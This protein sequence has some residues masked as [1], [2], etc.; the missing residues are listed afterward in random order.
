MCDGQRTDFTLVCFGDS[1]TEG[2]G[3]RKSQAWPALLQKKT[4]AKVVNEGASG[5]TAKNA[6]I[7]MGKI[8]SQYE[9]NAAFIVE[10]GA[11]DVLDALSGGKTPDFAL[12]RARLASMLSELSEKE[13]EKKKIF[14][15]KFYT[16]EMADSFIKGG[17]LFANLEAV[18]NSLAEEYG[19]EVIANLWDGIWD[20]AGKNAALISSDG[21]HPN[22]AGYKIMAENI[23]GSI[24]PYLAERELLRPSRR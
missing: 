10:F 12:L 7:R 13:P 23:F 19:A 3:A 24:S 6:L 4:L 16:K 22:A 14:L 11:N 8:V 9:T 17:A 2:K 15:V 1:L 21:L 20:E 5:E 18:Y